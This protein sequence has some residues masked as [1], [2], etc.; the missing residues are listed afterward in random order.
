MPTSATASAVTNTDAVSTTSPKPSRT[1]VYFSAT[2][3]SNLTTYYRMAGL[4]TISNSWKSWI[5]AGTPDPTAARYFDP[6]TGAGPASVSIANGAVI[7]R[8]QA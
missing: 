6:S 3:E 8:W 4:D 5:V 1:N 2:A 7:D